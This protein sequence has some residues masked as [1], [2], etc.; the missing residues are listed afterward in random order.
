MHR[1]CPR[2]SIHAMAKALCHLHGVRFHRYLVD[3]FRVAFDVYLEILRRV[4]NHVDAALNHG[5]ANWRAKNSCP[6]CH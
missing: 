4:D 3:Q 6:A 2:F 1:A 5:T